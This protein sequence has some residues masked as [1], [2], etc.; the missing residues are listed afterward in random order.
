MVG[1][2]QG[3]GTAMNIRLPSQIFILDEEMTQPVED[4]V[5]V[6][7]TGLQIE[8]CNVMVCN[9]PFNLEEGTEG[10][11]NGIWFSHKK[12]DFILSENEEIKV[13]VPGFDY[14]GNHCVDFPVLKFHPDAYKTLSV[15]PI[16]AFGLPVADA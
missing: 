6:V 1:T 4:A 7:M 2:M 8:K 3:K 14:E 5:N 10:S 15:K 13:V 16:I 12:L 11:C 9:P